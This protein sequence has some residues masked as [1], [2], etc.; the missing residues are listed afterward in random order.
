MHPTNLHTAHHARAGLASQQQQSAIR[1]LRTELHAQQDSFRQLQG[2]LAGK[3]RELQSKDAEIGVH[4]QNLDTL[5]T[6]VS[7]WEQTFDQHCAEA[8]SN[9]ADMQVRLQA[10]HEQVRGAY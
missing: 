8:E 6:A 4:T 2:E 7:G 1:E 9:A 10:G 3:A 5:Q